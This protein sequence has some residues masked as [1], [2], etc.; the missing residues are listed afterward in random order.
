MACDKCNV[1]Q[2]SAC[3][4]ISQAEAEKEDFQFVCHDCKRREEDAKKP[5][6][7]SLKFHIGSSSSPPSQKPK[8]V[9]PGANEG[10]KRKSNDG[11]S[12]LPPMKKYKPVN[13]RP[14]ESSQPLLQAQHIGQISHNGMQA[15]MMNGPILSPQGQIARSNYAGNHTE[16]LPSNRGYPQAASPPGLRSPPEP[17]RNHTNHV[18]G[19]GYIP[20]LPP[21]AFQSPYTT[22]GSHQNGHQPQNVGWS[23]RYTPPQQ[24]QHQQN[25]GPPPP[26]QNPFANSFDRQRPS[27]SHS[28]HNVPPPI[29]SG[30]LLSP[31]Q[32]NHIS[33]HNPIYQTPQPNGFQQHQ[34][35]PQTGPPAF[36]PVK[37]QSPPVAQG[38]IHHSQPSSSPVA[39]QPPLKANI[40]SSPGLSPTKHSPPH[41]APPGHGMTAAPVLPPGPQLSPSPTQNHFSSEIPAPMP[42]QARVPNG[43]VEQQ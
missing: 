27:S 25:Y 10:K 38:A 26:S 18:N 15:T 31:P 16:A 34:S 2:H 33:N 1:W 5:K 14:Q 22:T 41:A 8:V 21:Q 43:H 24:P 11:E 30:P 32:Q 7:P 3:L 29:K 39:H 4:G 40:F 35:L 17:P 12:N 20:Q 9:V 28:T 19:N 6:L 42:E 13:S 37:Q 36:S 23:A